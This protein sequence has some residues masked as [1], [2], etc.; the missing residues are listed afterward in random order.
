M[1]R[2]DIV[3]HAKLL[4]EHCEFAGNKGSGMIVGCTRTKLQGCLIAE[5][6]SG[7]AVLLSQ[8]N[9]KMLLRLS[10]IESGE[11]PKE[12]LIRGRVGCD[13][14]ELLPPYKE[15]AIKKTIKGRSDLSM[16]L[17]ALCD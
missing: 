11:N 16:M 1:I 13:Y 2:R 10:E 6:G 14:Q 5:N 8:I 7:W 17:D 15:L 3:A 4:F 9:A 12:K